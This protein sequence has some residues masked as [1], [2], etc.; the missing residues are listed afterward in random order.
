MKGRGQRLLKITVAS[1]VYP[2]NNER[3][4][5]STGRTAIQPLWLNGSTAP[6]ISDG[7]RNF[8]LTKIRLPKQTG[9]RSGM[10]VK[11]KLM[12]LCLTFHTRLAVGTGRSERGDGRRLPEVRMKKSSFRGWLRKVGRRI[13][14]GRW[15]S[16]SF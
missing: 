15:C 16:S 9:P 2:R 4:W 12:G 10:P 13:G 3:P 8:L 14:M 1:A 6:E 7:N 11:G 5:S